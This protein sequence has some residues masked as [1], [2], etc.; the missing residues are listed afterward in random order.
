M[1]RYPDT[2]HLANSCVLHCYQLNLNWI[3][4]IT[5]NFEQLFHCPFSHYHLDL[6]RCRYWRSVRQLYHFPDFSS[7]SSHYH[8]DCSSHSIS[9]YFT[10]RWHEW[11]DEDVGYL[12]W[13]YQIWFLNRWVCVSH[14]Q[15]SLSWHVP[16]RSP[17]TP[18]SVGFSETFYNCISQDQ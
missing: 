18:W 9:Y 3:Y 2:Q 8:P 14:F 6:K 15:L 13:E 5:F 11:L 4:L 1:L 12:F 16:S 10:L 7:S 17:L